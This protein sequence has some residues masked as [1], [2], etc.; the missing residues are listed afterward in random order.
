[1][2]HYAAGVQ[3]GVFEVYTCLT[4]RRPSTHPAMH[5]LPPVHLACTHMPFCCCCGSCMG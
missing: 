2:A 4:G 5:L 3:A 1:M